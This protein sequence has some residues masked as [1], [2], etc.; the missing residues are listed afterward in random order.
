MPQP[1]SKE[2]IIQIRNPGNRSGHPDVVLTITGPSYSIQINEPLA[3]E[4]QTV[5]KSVQE[6]GGVL[7]SQPHHRYSG[8]TGFDDIVIPPHD[9]RFPEALRSRVRA[10]YDQATV[11]VS[12]PTSPRR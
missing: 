8:R 10:L 1:E 7:Y 3:E 4:I 12:S 5:L 6:R 11:T 2:T 9:K